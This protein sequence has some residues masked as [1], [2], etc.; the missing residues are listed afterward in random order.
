VACGLGG[1]S[2]IN[3][4]VALRPEPRLWYDPRWPQRVRADLATSLEDGFLHAIEM[5]RPQPL[6]QD[7]PALPKLEAL[8]KSAAALGASDRFYRPPINVTFR[9]GVNH[10][11]V[12]QKRCIGCGDCVSGCNH[13]AKNTTLMNYLPDAASHGAEIYTCARVRSV[14][15]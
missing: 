14:A 3:A 2:L 7:Y 8:E 9:D 4:N 10:V 13:W 15:R 1:T 6:P 5:L 11:G 12:E